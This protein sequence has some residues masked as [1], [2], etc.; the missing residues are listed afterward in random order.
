[1]I[2]RMERDLQKIKKY[3]TQIFIGHVRCAIRNEIRFQIFL[4]YPISTTNNPIPYDKSV[5]SVGLV[6]LVSADLKSHNSVFV[7]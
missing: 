1:M 5:L 4:Q 7:L 3:N 6:A 2:N